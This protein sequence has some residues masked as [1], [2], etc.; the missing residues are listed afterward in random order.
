MSDLST[1]GYLL[2]RPRGEARV[3]RLVLA[4]MWHEVDDVPE[5]A[6]HVRFGSKADIARHSAHVRF[7]PI[8][9][10]GSVAGCNTPL[11]NPAVLGV[12]ATARPF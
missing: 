1:L 4:P 6:R 5:P 12:K 3:A 11:H 7:V 2:V 8:A 10:I 9:D